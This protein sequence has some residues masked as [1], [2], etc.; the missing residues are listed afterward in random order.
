MWPERANII[1]VWPLTKRN[2]RPLVYIILP[3]GKPAERLRRGVHDK[4]R[5]G[6]Q[7][8]DLGFV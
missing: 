5:I 7:G 6:I 2:C 8:V 4:Q 1:I 3:Q